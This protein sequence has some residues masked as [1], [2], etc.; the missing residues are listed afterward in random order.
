MF[1]RFTT[2]LIA[3][4]IDN[5]EATNCMISRNARLQQIHPQYK[6]R[7]KIAPESRMADETIIQTY[8]KLSP[9]WRKSAQGGSSNQNAK[10]IGHKNGFDTASLKK[11]IR[12]H[13]VHEY[14]M[15]ILSHFLFCC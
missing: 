4:E 1:W 6:H 12:R 3:L 11:N 13:L 15:L 8:F 9:F 14:Q 7:L 10:V 2:R 5:R